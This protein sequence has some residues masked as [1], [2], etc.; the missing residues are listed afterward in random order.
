MLWF[1]HYKAHEGV[2]RKELRERYETEDEGLDFEQFKGVV[3]WYA[4]AGLSEG[5][6]VIDLEDPI[7]LTAIL[8]PC[9]HLISWDVKA[10][11]QMDMEQERPSATYLR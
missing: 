2:T 6:V 10:C 8:Q 4:F 9:R 3:A 5:V 1:C 7:E 11:K